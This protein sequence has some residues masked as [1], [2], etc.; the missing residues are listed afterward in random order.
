MNGRVSWRGL[1]LA[2]MLAAAFFI[3]LGDRGLNEP[4]E[5]RYA[6]IAR[7][8]AV[9]G[10]WL[11]PHLNG[12]PHFQKPP[13]IYWATAVSFRCFGFNETAARLPSTLAALGILA[14]TFLIG[15][16]LF[17]PATATGAVFVLAAL[18]EFFALARMLTPDMVMSFWIVSAIFCLVK[19]RLDGGRIW[20]WLFF[21]A[22]GL[23]FATKGPMA[24][25]VPLPAALAW[26]TAA[27]VL[28][29]GR[30]L[31][32]LPGLL[33]AL[34]IGLS[35]FIVLALREPKLGSYF[36]GYEL[37]QRFASKIHGRAKPFWFFGPVLWF[38]CAPWSPVFVVM[39]WDFFRRW[40][41][42]WRPSA[43]AWLLV[44]WV[45]PPLFILS[46]SGSKLVTYVL[47]LLPALAI[48]LAHW[49]RQSPL[50]A[51]RTHAFSALVFF[52][53]AVGLLFANRWI[54]QVDVTILAAPFFLVGVALAVASIPFFNAR[55]VVALVGV[56]LTTLAGWLW[57]A[58]QA[59]RVNDLLGAQPSI[60]PLAR[61]VQRAPD[62]E[63]AT[64]FVVDARLPGWSFY[65][66]RHVCVS[67]A[68]S[69]VVLPLTG[70]QQQRLLPESTNCPALLESRAPAY[71]VIPNAEF[72]AVFS[73]NHWVILE[74]AGSYSLIATRDAALAQTPPVRT[75]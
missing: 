56:S 8:M 11:I 63:R 22:M 24:L 71:G 26:R 59:D 28:P 31:P 33:L 65:L 68:V 37:V 52:I 30:R 51:R 45:L 42:G 27:G 14:L 18:V 20:G 49:Q 38:G 74:H 34:G 12:I 66:Q 70:E 60:R 6:T 32:W 1:F 67:L 55:P 7:E 41:Q 10:D 58:T 46:V 53:T 64:L 23:G 75:P 3:E 40:R 21:I 15:R 73:T 29:K 36:A 44:G 47:P 69:D 5:G 17:G 43:K 19:H 2:V 35:W 9:D 50:F 39:A 72:R 57:V 25:V 48:G 62:L 4:D 54:H 13:I 61:L 16:K